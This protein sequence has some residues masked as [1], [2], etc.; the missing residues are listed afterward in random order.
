MIIYKSKAHKIKNSI[1]NMLNTLI[2]QD[3]KGIIIPY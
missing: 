3:K 1:N 2:S